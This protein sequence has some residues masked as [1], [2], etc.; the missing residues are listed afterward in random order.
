MANTLQRYVI[1]L[2]LECL[3]EFPSVTLQ[4]LLVG[5][6]LLLFLFI[7]ISFTVG[8]LFCIGVACYHLTQHPWGTV[9]M[10]RGVDMPSRGDPLPQGAFCEL[11]AGAAWAL[12]S[13]KWF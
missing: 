8:G 1:P 2:L 12:V 6:V 13:C 5:P 10:L 11:G 7:Y 9:R 4:L 3:S